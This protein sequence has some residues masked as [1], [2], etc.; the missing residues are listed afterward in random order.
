MHTHKLIPELNFY[1]PH[2]NKTKSQNKKERGEKIKKEGKIF[3]YTATHKTHSFTHT[4]THTHT[5]Y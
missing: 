5:Q 2:S 4:H 1:L 3:F